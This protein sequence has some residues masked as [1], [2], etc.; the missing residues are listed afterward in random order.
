MPELH[1]N[2]SG[3]TSR[4]CGPFTNCRAVNL[5]HLYR[6]EFDKTYFAYDAAYS[7]RKDL[8]KRTISD[9]IFKDKAYEIARSCGYDGYQRALTSMVYK[10]FDT[11]TASGVIVTSQR[12]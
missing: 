8:G 1:L 10:T 7:D 4:A 11:K 3:S 2:Q 6:N 5:N 12:E 9:N